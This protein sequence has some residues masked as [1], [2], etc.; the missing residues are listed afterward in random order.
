MNEALIQRLDA[1][2]RRDLGSLS[3]V[4]TEVLALLDRQDV[5]LS[6]LEQRIAQDQALAARILRIA[7]SPFYGMSREIA[8]L[9]EATVV[10]GVH[11]IRNVVTT[12]GVMAL[13]SG[14]SAQG[15]DRLAFWQHAIGVG[16]ASRVVGRHMGL[17]G[18]A[19]FTAGL[20]HDVGKLVIDCVLPEEFA[21]INEQVAETGCLMVEAER[22]ILGFDHSFTGGRVAERWK[23]PPPVI[24]AITRHHTPDSSSEAIVQAVHLGDILCRALEIG[25]G[26]DDGLPELNPSAMDRTGLDWSSIRG[27]LEEIDQLNASANLIL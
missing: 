17:E 16:I 5:D 26:G 20:L 13:F 19:A 14:D 1:G 22:Q 24:A 12:A 25:N 7:N 8:S 6:S 21:R 3:V 27:C 18:E 4:V 10:L 15:F 23:L 9:K 11:T 2:I